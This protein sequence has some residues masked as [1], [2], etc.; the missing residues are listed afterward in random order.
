VNWRHD[1]TSNA[2]EMSPSREAPIVQ[3]LMN[4]PAFYRTVGSSPC[5]QQLLYWSLSRARSVQSIPSQPIS[6]RWRL[7]LI[8][9]DVFWLNCLCAVFCFI[10]LCYFVRYV[11]FCVLCLIVVPL[12]PGKNPFAVQ[13]SNNDNKNYF[14]KGFG[15]GI[16]LISWGVVSG[17][18]I[19]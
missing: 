2:M 4:F 17:M 18:R 8:S 10:R 5:S 9:V 19:G 1:A 3:P 16:F 7:L 11:Y 12:P 14:G 13:L 15:L 6:P